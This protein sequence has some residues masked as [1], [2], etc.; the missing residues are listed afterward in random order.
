MEKALASAILLVPVV[1]GLAVDWRALAF[2]VGLVPVVVVWADLWA[3]HTCAK[4]VVP[5]FITGAL[6]SW[7]SADALASLNIKHLVGSTLIGSECWVANA[8]A[9]SR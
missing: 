4:V 3:A 6:A 9:V 1:V 5:D 2:A 8:F 7:L